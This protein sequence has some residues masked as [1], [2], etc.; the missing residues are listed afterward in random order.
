M[1]FYA[2]VIAALAGLAAALPAP[3]P[4]PAEA[5][6]TYPNENPGQSNR[7]PPPRA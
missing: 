5:I 3:A 4:A 6:S 1:K 7:W 2:I